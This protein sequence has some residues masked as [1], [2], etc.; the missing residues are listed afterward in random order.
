MGWH[1]FPHFLYD[2]QY[3]HWELTEAIVLKASKL[4]QIYLPCIS[5][6]LDHESVGGAL[7]EYTRIDGGTIMQFDA[8]NFMEDKCQDWKQG[9]D[10]YSIYLF[11]PHM[12]DGGS[13]LAWMFS[14][15]LEEDWGWCL[16]SHMFQA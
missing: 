3:Q 1:G 9:D 7:S 4:V 12:Y 15:P 16:S 10:I 13:D 6:D 11:A 8:P 2:D 14:C 5:T